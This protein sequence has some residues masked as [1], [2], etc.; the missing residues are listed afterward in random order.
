MTGCCLCG[1]NLAWR[2]TLLELLRW[3]DVQPPVICAACQASFAPWPAP[4]CPGCGRTSA[5]GQLCAECQ[6][7]QDQFGRLVPVTPCYQ[8]NQA[9]KNFMHRYKF[10]GDYQ[11]RRV[12]QA[13]LTTRA[14][15]LGSRVV[16]VPVSAE[17]MATRGFN[18]VNGLLALKRVAALKVEGQRK[19]RQAEKDRAARLA[20]PQPFALTK[21]A[22]SLAGQS[23]VLV[24][25]VYT[26]GRT[27]YH[28]AS[29][30]WQVGCTEIRG[31]VL[32]S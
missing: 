5:A 12:F 32:A 10:Q 14:G 26:T 20:T 4:H 27:F 24:D 21:A 30:L 1:G 22:Q 8:Y 3:G 11:L 15:Q 17:T 2:P 19:G 6:A 29:L 16:T 31:L 25:D 9:M 18:Q 23:V 28:A 13:E 7:W